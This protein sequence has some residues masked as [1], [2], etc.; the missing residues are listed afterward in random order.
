MADVGKPDL[1]QHRDCLLRYALLQLRDRDP[2]R[3]LEDRKFREMFE[4]C[5]KLMP[6]RTAR[7]FMMREVLELS[8]D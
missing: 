2:A 7:V 1:E 4:P 3:A 6:E 8:T 5:A